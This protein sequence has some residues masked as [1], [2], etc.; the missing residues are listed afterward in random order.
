MSEENGNCISVF[1]LSGTFKRSFGTKGKEFGQFIEPKGI[2][3]ST[4]TG[5]ASLIYVCDMWNNRIQVFDALT[6]DFV[7]MWGSH[8]TGTA[9][10]WNPTDVKVSSSGEE[11]YVTETGNHR[12]SVFR[13]SGK[14]LRVLG[15]E[16]VADGHLKIPRGLCLTNDGTLLV[17]EKG[18]HRIQ[19]LACKDGACLRK[20]GRKG[21]NNGEFLGPTGI[22]IGED[23]KVY[24]CDEG[25]AG[26]NRLQVFA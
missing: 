11:V 3:I 8:G 24:V 15:R 25:Y 14:P 17:C 1:A 26:G 10:L 23:G 2:C 7:H 18:N 5:S 6:G 4:V 13:P 12:I 21:V 19:E 20:W 16:G 22:V 9:Q